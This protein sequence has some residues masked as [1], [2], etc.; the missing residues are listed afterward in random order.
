MKVETRQ[1]IERQIARKAVE[2]MIAG[3]YAVTVYDGEEIALEAATDVKAV[4]AAMFTTD[5]DYLFA[6]K[7]DE[8]GK[9]ERQGWARFIYGNDGWDVMSDYTTNLE[10]VLAGAKAEADKLE[11]RHG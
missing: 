4:M 9:M 11:A 7:P 8:A 1:K 6:M 2:G 5:E 3:G 10:S